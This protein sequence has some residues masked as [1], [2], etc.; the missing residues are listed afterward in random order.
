MRVTTFKTVNSIRCMWKLSL[1]LLLLWLCCMYMNTD[2]RIARIDNSQESSISSQCLMCVSKHMVVTL[3]N[4]LISIGWRAFHSIGL[5]LSHIHTSM[6]HLKATSLYTCLHWDLVQN[7]KTNS[8][9]C[10]A[11]YE[12]YI[13]RYA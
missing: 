8:S 9:K 4:V 1:L 12:R 5:L 3:T 13:D 2:I 11:S 7:T 10:L 6:I